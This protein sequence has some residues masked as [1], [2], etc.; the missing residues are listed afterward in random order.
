MA[1]FALLDDNNTVIQIVVIDDAEVPS[2]MHP[3]GELYC[4]KLFKTG[5]WK[6]YSPDSSFR[7]QRAGFG[8]VYDEAKDIFIPPNDHT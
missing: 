7:K 4:K 5:P 8:H 2:D 6:Q 1:S 3:D